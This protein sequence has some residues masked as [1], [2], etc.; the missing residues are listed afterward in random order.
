MYQVKSLIDH[1]LPPAHR[2]TLEYLMRHLKRVAA[3]GSVNKMESS[4]LALIFSVGLLRPRYEDIQS[5]VNASLQSKI[6][7]A[8]IQQVD[9]F[10]DAPIE[11]AEEE[12]EAVMS[13]EAEVM[14]E[15]VMMASRE[16]RPEE[17]EVVVEREVVVVAE[18]EEVVVEAQQEDV[19]GVRKQESI[20]DKHEPMVEKPVVKEQ[21]PVVEK[22]E[23]VIEKQPVEAKQEPLVKKQE[24][25]VE[26]GEPM[27]EKQVME[28]Q[29]PTVEKQE[30]AVE[31]QEPMVEKQELTVEK[32]ES[33]VENQ[34]PMAKKQE[35]KGELELVQK[36][37]LVE[38]T[39]EVWNGGEYDWEEKSI[40]VKK[41]AAEEHIQVLTSTVE[42]Q[43]V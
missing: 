31:K 15:S 23:P 39:Q 22:Q 13:D 1:A 26:K 36:H 8:I 28:K 35:S 17:G 11:M 18:R 29:E 33:V 5:I 24:P 21:E 2:A 9:W 43:T 7:E 38:A 41:A 40:R 10:F 16:E 42:E 25:V 32:Q 4:N 14:E 19:R 34:Q 27:V 20:V 12:P 30:P 6:I 37:E 3:K